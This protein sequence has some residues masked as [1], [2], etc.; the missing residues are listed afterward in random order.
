MKNTLLFLC[1]LATINASAQRLADL[2]ND[3]IDSTDKDP[4]RFNRDNKVYKSNTE[5]VFDY[6]IVKDKDSLK[7]R[8][9][10]QEYGIPK[11]Q[12]VK[13]DDA[14]TLTV[15]S[16]GIAVLPYYINDNQTGIN[17]RYYN[18]FGKII[19]NS[20]SSGLIEN[21]KN[22]WLHPP[23]SQ[24]FE[25]T[26]FNSFP[27]IKTPY[28][29]G[30]KWTSG[31]T[32]GYFDSYQRFNLTWEGILNTRETLEIIDKVDLPT[33]FGTLPCF[34]VQGICKSDLTES[35]SLFYY[36]ETYGFVRITYYLFDKS[37]L[38]FNLKAVK[39]IP[40]PEPYNPFKGE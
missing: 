5:F 7:C 40:P 14:D 31:L 20:T 15:H 30:T 32:V 18:K 39:K 9:S 11:W 17:F 37:F 33:A 34:V 23:R 4:R 26:E 35:K 19:D 24:F 25:I 2:E 10:R 36:N 38:E 22:T 6:V 1:F 27:F 29:I 3:K 16:L 13:T 28:A 21:D 8:F 12:L